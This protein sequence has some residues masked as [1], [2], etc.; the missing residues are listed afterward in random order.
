MRMSE[1]QVYLRLRFFAVYSFAILLGVAGSTAH[2]QSTAVQAAPATAAP[3]AAAGQAA[4]ATQGIMRGHISDP[5]GALIPG[6]SITVTT[7]AGSAAG[8]A[9]ADAAGGYLVRGLPAGSYVVQVTADGF[10]LSVSPP[11]PLTAGQS[12]TLDVKMS[13]EGTT[14]EV[15]VDSGGGTPQVSTDPEG[16]ANSVVLKGTDLDALSDDPDELSNELSAL[17]GPAA[18]P[19]GGQIYIDGFTAGELPPK[20]AIREIRINSNP[21]SAEFDRLGYGRIEVLTKPGTDT[22]HGRGFVQGNDN[23]FD[24]GNPFASPIPPYHSLQ[25]NGTIS[26][27]ISKKASYF[28]SAE[29]RDNQNDAIYVADTGTPSL[30]TVGTYNAVQGQ[31]SGGYFSPSTHTNISPRIDLQFGQKNT[32][33]VRYQFFDNHSTGLG[34][35][36]SLPSLA[37][38]SSSIEHTIQ[39]SD[40]EIISPRIVNEARFQYLLDLTNQSPAQS[41]SVLLPQVGVSGYFSSGGSTS[42]IESDKTQHYFFQDF[43]TMSAGTH[44]IKFGTWIRNNV[45]T[46]TADSSFNGSFSF[47][48]VTAYLDTV[49]GMANGKTVAEIYAECPIQNTC[50]PNKLNYATGAQ[51][52]TGNLF[53]SAL[54]FQ[55]DWKKSK[56]LTL[57]L[58]VRWETE[59]HI[60]DHSDFAPRVAFAYALDGHKSGAVSKTILR[61]GYGFFYDRLG[62]GSLMSYERYDGKPG[63]QQQIVITEP[64]CFSATS[65][66]AAQGQAGYTYT[67]P[68]GSQTT[69]ANNCASGT[70]KTQI[71]VLDPHYHS[72]VHEQFGASLERQLTKTT[73]MTTT[74]LHTYGVHQNGTIDANAYLPNNGTVFYNAT[75]GPTPGVRP[76]PNF[77]PIDETYPE[78]I[79]KQNQLIL[80]LNSRLSPR[81]SVSGYYNM[82]WANSNSGTFSNSYNTMQDYGAASFTSRQQMMLMGNYTGPWNITFNP[83]LIAQAGRP[84]SIST[85]S[86]LTGDNFIGRDRPAIASSATLPA[87]LV[88]TSFGSFDLQPT[89]GETIIPAQTLVGPAAVAVNLRIARSWGLGPEVVAPAGRRPG[90]GGG[91]RP[92]GGFGGIGGGRGGPGGG[93]GGPGGGSGGMGG[94]GRKYSLNFSAQ[95]LNMFN[96]VDYG[97][98]VGSLTQAVPGQPAVSSR[99]DRSKTLAG[100]IF[101][102]AASSRRMF[103]QA[104]FQF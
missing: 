61:G 20:S 62:I 22:L 69:I 58:G 6:A 87:N 18:G 75:T 19:N 82:N 48:S 29:Q 85:P 98:P 67:P 84:F 46:N 44:A 31:C 79:Y 35:S 52:V 104:A 47:P 30:C 92:G 40:D 77:G 37:N 81:F 14:Q 9:T 25:Y 26:G 74:Y 45:D 2:A 78:A 51:Y 17:A 65:L 91:G 86:D 71:N 103:I 90:G 12:R 10:A 36:G 76:N 34:G 13:V 11:I 38:T 89:A 4:P 28:F 15:E 96:D 3:T 27:A 57:S 99:F 73:T 49:N 55:D 93:F 80:S 102:T 66:S 59:N 60:A 63:S 68:G 50:T 41:T 23:A 8:S 64:T 83:F 5:T 53:D 43:V 70:T 100:G 1:G 32:L 95:A 97:T 24:T 16:N 72:P 7:V 101:S 42:Q 94:T 56:N 33:T 39:F 88:T 21:F 54:Y